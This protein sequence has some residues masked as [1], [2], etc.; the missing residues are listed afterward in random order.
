MAKIYNFSEMTKKYRIFIAHIWQYDPYYNTIVNWIN[1]ANLN[2]EKTSRPNEDPI[3]KRSG[4]ILLEQMTPAKIVVVAGDL[5]YRYRFLIDYQI[6]EAAKM[7]KIII[8]VKPCDYP[9]IPAILEE[10]ATVIVE[11]NQQALIDALK[12]YG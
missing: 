10:K 9:N 1:D 3:I 6:K 2:W 11:W 4:N 12:T 8:G 5:Y 7:Q